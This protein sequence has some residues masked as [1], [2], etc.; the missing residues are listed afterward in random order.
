[1]CRVTS[2]IIKLLKIDDRGHRVTRVETDKHTI[3]VEVLDKKIIIDDMLFF[4]SGLS[5]TDIKLIT[6]LTFFPGVWY[7]DKSG[8]LQECAKKIKH[9][10]V[11]YT[12]N[13]DTLSILYIESYKFDKEY[14]EIKR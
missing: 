8:M 6:L 11:Y 2:N 7:I 9:D 13:P 1:M 14:A 10:L 12:C 5:E 3:K 4:M